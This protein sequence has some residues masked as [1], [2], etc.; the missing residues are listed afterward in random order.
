MEPFVNE[1]TGADRGL[2]VLVP[3]EAEIVREKQ[4]A[5]LVDASTVSFEPGA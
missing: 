1:T 3:A 2:A 4:A 5:V